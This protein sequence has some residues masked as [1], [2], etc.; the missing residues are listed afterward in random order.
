MTIHVDWAHVDDVDRCRNDVA[1][2]FFDVGAVG[3]VG[4]RHR[5]DGVVEGQLA[6]LWVAHGHGDA[7]GAGA[8]AVDD[9][10][11]AVGTGAGDGSAGGADAVAGAATTGDSAAEAAAV[12]AVRRRRSVGEDARRAAHRFVAAADRTAALPRSFWHTSVAHR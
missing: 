5:Q 10:A 7:D 11:V 4:L 12:G 2:L 8:G 9:A 3:V 1:V 6:T